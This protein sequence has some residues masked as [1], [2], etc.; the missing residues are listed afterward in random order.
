M[1]RAVRRR[2]RCAPGSTASA[3]TP[4][5][6]LPGRVFPTDMKA[7]PLLRAWLHR[8]REAGVQFHMR[9]RWLGWRDGQLVFAS[10]DGEQLVGGRRGD[11]GAGRRQLGA[12]R[13]GRR[14]GWRCWKQESVA[15]AP[16]APSN[17]GFDV[18]WS[19][20]FS[21]RHAGAP[22]TTVAIESTGRRRPA[23][24]PPGPVRGHRDRRRRQ[25]DLRAVGAAARPDRRATA[26][27]PSGSTWRPTSA[28]SGSPPKSRIRAA[29][30]RCRA[31]CKAGSGSRASNRA[32]CANA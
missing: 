15:V 6:A 17:C 30:A 3:S 25:P 27:P 9:H 8:L 10:P 11:P 16:L 26:A 2:R 23:G 1:A 5:S 4:S 20:H 21:S 24:A 28:R 14:L 7:A 29:R 31:I 19:A 22:L 12:A 32:C 13:I 18:D